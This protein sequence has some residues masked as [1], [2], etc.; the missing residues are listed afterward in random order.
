MEGVDSGELKCCVWNHTRVRGIHYQQHRR[1]QGV[2]WVPTCT[3]RRKKMSGQ[4]YRGKL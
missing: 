3:P 4:I 1:S 2:H